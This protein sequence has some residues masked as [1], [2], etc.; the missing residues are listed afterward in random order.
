MTWNPL[1]MRT[2]KSFNVRVVGR[3][4]RTTGFVTAK[5]A[6]LLR[7]FGSKTSWGSSLGGRSSVRMAA[8][9]AVGAYSA[10]HRFFG[11][12]YVRLG[13]LA[14]AA[15]RPGLRGKGRFS[16]IHGRTF[17][18]GPSSRMASQIISIVTRHRRR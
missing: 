16:G 2:R 1:K 15:L 13:S 14:H 3:L 5:P 9:G 11:N 10:G 7:S 17:G 12:Q 18:S 4:G 8:R 6:G